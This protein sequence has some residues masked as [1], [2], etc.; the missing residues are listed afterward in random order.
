[1]IKMRHIVLNLILSLLSLTLLSCGVG[2]AGG[3]S[4]FLT[5]ISD[6]MLLDINAGVQQ[7][8]HT[9][10]VNLNGTLLFIAG[11]NHEIW[12]STAAGVATQL[13]NLTTSG[14]TTQLIADERTG[15][16]ATRFYFWVNGL[17]LWTSNTTT[18]AK[19]AER[20]DGTTVIAEGVIGNNYYYQTNNFKIYKSTAGATPVELT[21]SSASFAAAVTFVAGTS[22]MY[23]HGNHATNQVVYSHS[24]AST[25]PATTLVKSMGTNAS[26]GASGV[27][28]DKFYF[29]INDTDGNQ[30]DNKVYV[31]SAGAVATEVTDDTSASF[32]DDVA[33]VA[34]TSVMYIYGNH[35]TDKKIYAHT[36]ATTLS[37][38]LG[39]NASVSSYGIMGNE[40]YFQVNDTDGNENDKLV[41]KAAPSTATAEVTDNVGAS[42][43]ADVSFISGSA[44]MYILGNHAT[45]HLLYSHTG[46]AATTSTLVFTDGA[47]ASVLANGVLGDDLYF[48]IHDTD[49]D[50]NNNRVYKSVAGAAAGPIYTTSSATHF[51]EDVDFGAGTTKMYIYGN[52]AS[53]SRAYSHSGA[54]GAAQLIFSS[55]TGILQSAKAK[56]VGDTL[57][58][59]GRTTPTGLFA[60][61][62]GAAVIPVAD[63]APSQDDDYLCT[64]PYT[65]VSYQSR[66]FFVAND[67]EAGCELWTTTGTTASTAL[68]ADVNSGDAHSHPKDL[69][70]VGSRLY[71]TALGADGNRGLYYSESPYTSA[72]QVT[73]TGADSN[74]DPHHLTAVGTKLYFS[75][76][77]SGAQILYAHDA[78]GSAAASKKQETAGSTNL[79]LD[80][81]VTPSIVALGTTAIVRGMPTGSGNYELY[82]SL[83]T[84]A[85]ATSATLLKEI[86]ASGSA[87]PTLS[88]AIYNGTMFFTATDGTNGVEL[89]KTGGTLATTSMIANINQDTGGAA[90]SNPSNLTL[91]RSR[92]YFTAVDGGSAV[93]DKELWVTVSPFTSVTK[94]TSF[95]GDS[96]IDSLKEFDSNT[97][98]FTASE[99]NGTTAGIYK[100]E[101]TLASTQRVFN[102]IPMANVPSFNSTYGVYGSKLFFEMNRDSGAYG[103][104]LW[105]TT[106]MIGET[107]MFYDL[108]F[109]TGS[110]VSSHMS[111]SQVNSCLVFV[112][113]DGTQGSELWYLSSPSATEPTLL[114]N[115][116]PNDA[117]G[118]APVLLGVTS[119]AAYYII[120]D[121]TNG[122]TLYKV[123]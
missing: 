88:T 79:E 29:Q 55:G 98:I 116:N 52:H 115:I 5:G 66:L 34:G 113:N 77:I 28:G 31:S 63:F 89:W 50:E 112:G 22:N 40:L 99:D 76:A 109:G 95:T 60:S 13:K 33:F 90:S 68:V 114:R 67:G 78:T 41:F 51:T 27:I 26:V 73:L 122:K 91:I 18:T 74:P 94:L 37:M 20:D 15:S 32:A 12:K 46:V 14:S 83:S 117:S 54:A 108:N 96:K 86:N 19:I 30:D 59:H 38:A 65:P 104:E 81:A 2:G 21:A 123:Q 62:A 35:A 106:G 93:N 48:Q 110:G 1:M 118:T 16:T 42:F 69:T 101:G 25:S 61:V 43:V 87:S 58:F 23:F 70:L 49:G 92:L 97:L 4:V 82:T 103:S 17:Q 57:F 10:W 111:F 45:N 105:S 47:N 9:G 36:I 71:F 80:P 24:A 7:E 11:S 121:G 84:A 120:D 64:T 119:N 39:T 6:N 75:A 102:D 53:N 8:V 3:G 107:S 100:T 56:I 72:V 85:V 44:H